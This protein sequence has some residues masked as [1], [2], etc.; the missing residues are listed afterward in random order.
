MRKDLWR[1]ARKKTSCKPDPKLQELMDRYWKLIVREK[2]PKTPNITKILD[3]LE[4]EIRK[5][6][7]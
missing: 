1:M 5:L 4:D 3:D 2:I 7:K 6:K